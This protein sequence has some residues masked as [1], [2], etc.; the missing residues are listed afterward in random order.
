MARILIAEDDEVQR[1]LLHKVLHARG[2]EVVA[3]V[4]GTEALG[5]LQGCGY[6]LL[7][8]DI[9][10]P[11]LDGIGLALRVARDCPAV[12]IILMTGYPDERDRARN[13]DDLVHSVICKPFELDEMLEA[14]DQAVQTGS[15]FS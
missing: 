4:D 12:P 15:V 13:L 11:G 5:A 14:V 1:T 6:D 10:M 7:I 2:H 8:T 9:V 3:V